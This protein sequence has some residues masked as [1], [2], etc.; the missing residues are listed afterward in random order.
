MSDT[1]V[2]E[3]V[4]LSKEG[5]SARAIAIKIGRSA[6]Y[7]RAILERHIELPAKREMTAYEYAYRNWERARTAARERLDQIA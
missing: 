3:I 6:S 7:V 5:M 1:K 4:R 2:T